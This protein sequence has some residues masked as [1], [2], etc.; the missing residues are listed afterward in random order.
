ML[1][2]IPLPPTSQ[3]QATWGTHIQD[4][5]RAA[6]FSSS[7]VIRY[8]RG[9]QENIKIAGPGEKPSVPLSQRSAQE[10][11]LAANASSSSLSALVKK[12]AAGGEPPPVPENESAWDRDLRLVR[13]NEYWEGRIV[14]IAADLQERYRT[15]FEDVG[16]HQKIAVLKMLEYFG[17]DRDRSLDLLKVPHD[18]PLGA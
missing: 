9:Q 12:T 15:C 2:R 10:Q 6:N 14:S 5:V 13:E 3:A 4:G 1:P 18:T 7:V 11:A 17:W 8:F 16:V